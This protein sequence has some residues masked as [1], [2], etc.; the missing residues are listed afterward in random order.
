MWGRR[1]VGTQSVSYTVRAKRGSQM[2]AWSDALTIRF[3]RG[4][5][6][7]S[8]DSTQTEAVSPARMAA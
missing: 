7:L 3:G 1:W 8:I 6:G 4:G 5:G 2:S